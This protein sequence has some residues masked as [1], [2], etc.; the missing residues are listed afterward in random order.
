MERVNYLQLHMAI[1]RCGH[2]LPSNQWTSADMIGLSTILS[3]RQCGISGKTGHHDDH[4]TLSNILIFSTK[5]PLP[6]A[7]RSYVQSQDHLLTPAAQVNVALSDCMK[8]PPQ[9]VASSPAF[10]PGQPLPLAST[11][12]VDEGVYWYQPLLQHSTTGRHEGGCH[13]HGELGR[14]AHFAQV[15]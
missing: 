14:H 8:R 3:S 7:K 1:S 13:E 15:W 9:S 6:A 2:G 10:L 11:L 5:S 12:T 4:P